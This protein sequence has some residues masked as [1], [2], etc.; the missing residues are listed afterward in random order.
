MNADGHKYYSFKGSG[1]SV[2]GYKGIQ[3]RFIT[4]P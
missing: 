1:F 3:L 2:Q 4:E